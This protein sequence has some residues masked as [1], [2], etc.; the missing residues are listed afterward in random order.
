MNSSHCTI[1]LFFLVAASLSSLCEAKITCDQVVG[2]LKPCVDYL[3]GPNGA[4]PTSV[5]CDGAKALEEATPTKE[6][7]R[8]ACQCAKDAAQKSQLKIN[9]QNAN[10]LPKKCNIQPYPFKITPNLDCNK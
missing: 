6:D 10:D 5:C 3:T 1:V 7:I 9:F 8:A 4:L 2:D